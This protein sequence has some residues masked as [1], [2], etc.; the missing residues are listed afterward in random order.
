MAKEITLEEAKAE[1]TALREQFNLLKD[2]PFQLQQALQEN[3]SLKA[4]VAELGPESGE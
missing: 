4:E 1:I 3:E 2:T